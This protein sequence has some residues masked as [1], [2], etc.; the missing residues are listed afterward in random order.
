MST[1]KILTCADS[2]ATVAWG[3][4]VTVKAF[5]GVANISLCAKFA[6]LLGTNPAAPTG[7]Q[8][9]AHT[10]RT[11]GWYIGALALSTALL[12]H[13]LR[14]KTHVLVRGCAFAQQ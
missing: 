4:V 10:G 14:N 1:V 2:N 3:A 7:V 11:L 9:Q 6:Q 13:S 12:S 5:V 8:H